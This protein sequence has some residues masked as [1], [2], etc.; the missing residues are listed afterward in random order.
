MYEGLPGEVK[1]FFVRCLMF[2][3]EEVF[4]SALAHRAVGSLRCSSPLGAP[5]TRR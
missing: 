1:T 2:P 4:P 3:N 5:P